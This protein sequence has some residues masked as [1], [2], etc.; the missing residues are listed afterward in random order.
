M[1][2]S[3]TKT[4]FHLLS[5]RW[6][7]AV[8]GNVVAA[9]YRWPDCT[10][11]SAFLQTWHLIP[12]FHHSGSCSSSSFF[13]IATPLLLG[14]DEQFRNLLSESVL[15]QSHWVSQ[16]QTIP[17]K[18][19]D[20]SILMSSHLKKTQ[21]VTRLTGDMIRKLIRDL[22]LFITVLPNWFYYVPNA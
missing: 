14:F 4:N 5:N 19:D 22:T 17:I 21:V 1:P 15:C 12:Y 11:L 16:I 18:P 9:S 6:A 3:H 10:S 20:Q 13:G 2:Q 7:I 8:G